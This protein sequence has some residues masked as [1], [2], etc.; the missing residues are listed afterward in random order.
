MPT[1]PIDLSDD[2]HAA[3]SIIAGARDR[4]RAE[5][6]GDAI[7]ACITRHGHTLV[8]NGFGLRKG[9]EIAGQEDLRSEW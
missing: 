2:Q 3:L 5:I 6:I 7:D 9:R 8:N 1:I 4:P